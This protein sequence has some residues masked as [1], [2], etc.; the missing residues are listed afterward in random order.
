MKERGIRENIEVFSRFPSMF[1]FF[2]ARLSDGVFF[3]S[4]TTYLNRL[5]RLYRICEERF[6]STM[7]R[8]PSPGWMTGQGRTATG[9]LYASIRPRIQVVGRQ[10]RRITSSLPIR[11]KTAGSTTRLRSSWG[12]TEI[13]RLV[14]ASGSESHKTRRRRTPVWEGDAASPLIV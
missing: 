12:Y 11:R 13:L 6:L 2:F 5:K 1:F 9:E 3:G 14:R 10:A 4:W 8:R 7:T